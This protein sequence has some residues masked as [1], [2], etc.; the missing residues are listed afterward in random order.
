[1]AA[2]RGLATRP[3]VDALR[4]ALFSSLG[5]SVEGCR[6]ADLFAGTG[7]YGL[8][9]VSRGAKSGMFVEKHSQCIRFLRGNL[10][11]VCK[12]A[13]AVV[14]N[15]P[16]LASDVFKPWNFTSG[17]FDL[18]FAD[19]PYADI[20]AIN[21]R[22]FELAEGMLESGGIFVFEKPADLSFSAAGWKLLKQLGKKRGQGPSV[23]IWQRLNESVEFE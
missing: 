12:S 14:D 22:L 6:F 4:E 10:E 5:T 11:A 2:P 3:A 18:V 8:E 23:D 20:S 17:K 16:V 21:S 15:F 19:P 9:A 13:G 7:A 1:L